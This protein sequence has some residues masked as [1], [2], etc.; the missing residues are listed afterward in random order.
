MTADQ[1][2]AELLKQF[3]DESKV[4]IFVGSSQYLSDT[5]DSGVVETKLTSMYY[6][7]GNNLQPGHKYYV[8]IQVYSEKEGWS[9]VQIKSFVMPK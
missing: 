1:L 4:R 6:G 3:D 2:K 7:G 8:H 5:W 9:E